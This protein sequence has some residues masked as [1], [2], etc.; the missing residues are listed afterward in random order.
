MEYRLDDSHPV[1]IRM[2]VTG[3]ADRPGLLS[4]LSELLHH[5]AYTD[6]HSLWDFSRADMGVSIR[7]LSEIAG[8]SKTLT[9]RP[10]IWTR[11]IKKRR[12]YGTGLRC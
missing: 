9:M 7:D 5:P 6:K 2:T 12:S 10:H 1:Y 3:I 11:K 8:I 4:A